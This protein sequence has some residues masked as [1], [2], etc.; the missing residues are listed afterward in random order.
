MEIPYPQPR[1]IIGIS[2]DDTL[3]EAGKKVWL[4][5][6]AEMLCHESG[7][8]L[9]ENIEELHDMRVATR[10]MRSAFDIFS[11]AFDAKNHET[12]S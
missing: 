7:T 9:G 2:P 6:F 10:R 3:A 4:Y 1:Q 12:P 11:P 5:Y 8:I